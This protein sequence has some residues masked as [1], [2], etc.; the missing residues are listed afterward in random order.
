M[1]DAIEFRGTVKVFELSFHDGQHLKLF[2]PDD[3]VLGTFQFETLNIG[4]GPLSMAALSLTGK[5]YIQKPRYRSTV[6]AQRRNVTS[7][8]SAVPATSGYSV[9]V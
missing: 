8:N 5:T 1:T 6:W 2:Q 3:F 9:Q 4:P 7:S